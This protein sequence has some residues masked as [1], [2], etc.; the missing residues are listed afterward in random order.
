MDEVVL[1]HRKRQALAACRLIVADVN[2]NRLDSTSYLS[3][4]AFFRQL[5]SCGGVRRR[6]FDGYSTTSLHQP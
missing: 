5:A 4:A 2:H 6:L 3:I 1:L